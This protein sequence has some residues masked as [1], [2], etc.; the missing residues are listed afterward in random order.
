MPPDLASADPRRRYNVNYRAA[1]DTACNA[2]YYMPILRL[3]H[4]GGELNAWR[5]SAWVARL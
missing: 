3:V 2:M 4:E 5:M 1:F